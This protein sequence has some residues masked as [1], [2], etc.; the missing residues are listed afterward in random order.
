MK[1]KKLLLLP[2][3]MASLSGCNNGNIVDI[4]ILSFNDFHGAV[5][6]SED[7]SQQ[8]LLNFASTII[9]KQNKV[10]NGTVLLSAGDMYQGSAESNTGKG[11]IMMDVMNKLGLEAMTIGNHEFDW[12]VDTIISQHDGDTKNGEANYDYLGCNIYQVQENKELSRVDWAK[13]Y[14]IVERGD[15]KIGIIGWIATTCM[16][17]IATSIVSPYEFTNPAERIVDIAYKLRNEDNCDLIVAMGHDD[18]DFVNTELGTNTRAKIDLI[19]N[20]HSHS[21]YVKEND[22]YNVVQSESNGAYLGVTNIRYNREEKK[23]ISMTTVN[24]EIQDVKNKDQEIKTIIDDNLKDINKVV[25]EVIGKAGE[26][27]T[28]KIG[29]KWIANAIKGA[30]GADVGIINAGGVREKAFP[31]AKGSDIKV[32]NIWEMM[33]FDNMIKTTKITGKD[34]KGLINNSDNFIFSHTTEE[35]NAL[36]DTQE[37]VVAACDY[38]FDKPEYCFQNGKDVTETLLLVRDAMIEDVK[39]WTKENLEFMPSQGA[40]VGKITQ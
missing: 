21:S 36:D 28:K 10:K 33:P 32:S 19:I 35:I 20:G 13:D 8:G 38:I 12:G 30:T 9:E 39:A 22:G 17:D 1:F 15:I 27:I 14:K 6:Q 3:L 23:V 29:G 24:E 31:I 7:G 37:Y 40:K 4:Q 25:N 11:K 18:S 16:N 34:V 2:L 26:K 5:K